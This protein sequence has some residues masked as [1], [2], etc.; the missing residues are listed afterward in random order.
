MRVRTYAAWRGAESSADQ[1]N[2]C[3]RDQKEE[4]LP[5]GNLSQIM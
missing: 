3:E 4:V 5:G 2:R 1:H